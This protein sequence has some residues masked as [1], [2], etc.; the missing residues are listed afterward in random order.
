VIRSGDSKGMCSSGAN[1]RSETLS[2][3][4]KADLAEDLSLAMHLYDLERGPEWRARSS[5]ILL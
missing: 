2:R 3:F 4:I 1:S 5:W